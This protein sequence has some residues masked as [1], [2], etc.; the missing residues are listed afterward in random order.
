MNSARRVGFTRPHYHVRAKQA[1]PVCAKCPQHMPVQRVQPKG[2]H[3]VHRN[4]FRGA[5]SGVRAVVSAGVSAPCVRKMRSPR[6]RGIS[7]RRGRAL[8][9]Q[10]GR[11]KCL[12][13]RVR[14][15]RPCQLSAQGGRVMPAPSRPREV[16]AASAGAKLP[17]KRSASCSEG[18]PQKCLRRHVRKMSAPRPRKVAAPYLRGIAAGNGRPMSAEWPRHQVRAKRPRHHARAGRPH[19]QVREKCPRRMPAKMAAQ[20]AR[21]TS[22]GMAAEVPSEVSAASRP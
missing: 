14:A 8:S 2:S 17:R 4:G 5:R 15:K 1:R 19:H 18:W 11:T 9:A 13:P 10:S 21:I 16:P 6:L 12:H 20:R 3:S 22:E 7:A